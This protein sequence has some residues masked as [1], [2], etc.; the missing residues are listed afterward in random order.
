MISGRGIMSEDRELPDGPA[1]REERSRFLNSLGKLRPKLH[2]ICARMCG[3]VLDGE[4]LVQETLAAA[5]YKLPPMPNPDFLERSLFRMAIERCLTFIQLD[6]G[7]R[8]RTTLSGDAGKH[9]IGPPMSWTKTSPEEARL[10]CAS[11]LPRYDRAV[12]VL[13]DVLGFSTWETMD[14]LNSRYG[15]IRLAQ[16]RARAT[17]HKLLPRTPSEQ[18][19]PELLAIP[20]AYAECFNRL[21]AEGLHRIVRDDARLEIVGAFN[22]RMRELDAV[23]A[24]TYAAN[25]W[26]WTLTVVL[27]DGDPALVTSRRVDD[28]WHAYSAIRLWWEGARVVRIR[29]YMQIRYVLRDARIERVDSQ[30]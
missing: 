20:R 18:I 17:L 5:A 9:L 22:G 28:Q 13:M 2:R 24:G 12:I 14:L 7:H 16:L 1:R 10:L 25:P 29:D 21:D 23:Y 15:E 8:E 30:H 11:A 26:D 6:L 19:R 27:V 4:D 3:S